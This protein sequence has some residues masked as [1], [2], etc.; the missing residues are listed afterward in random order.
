MDSPDLSQRNKIHITPLFC[1]KAVVK[2]SAGISRG[3]NDFDSLHE[4]IA[5]PSM[6]CQK[7]SKTLNRKR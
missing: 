5:S 1:F 3:F 7:P 2:D 6:P 4:F